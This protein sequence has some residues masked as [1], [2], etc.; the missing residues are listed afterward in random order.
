MPYTGAKPIYV[1]AKL[2]IVDDEILRVGSA[3]M[4]NRSMGLDSEADVFID[5]R[6]PANDRA[7]VRGTI[8]GIRHKLLAEHC[9]LEPQAI[10]V[11]LEEHG[12]MAAMIDALP[13]GPKRLEPFVLRPLNDA[14][15][16]LADSAVLDPERPGE[17][18][19]PM[20]RSGLF[21]LGGILHR[22]R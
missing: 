14:E 12:S 20:R 17:L 5:A 18:F 10:P 7:E 1:H 13:R 2:T 19:E 21:K 11:L 15:K 8:Q 16:A 6:R 3:N 4:N 22:P 9:G